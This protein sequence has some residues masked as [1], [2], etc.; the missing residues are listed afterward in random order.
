MENLTFI[1]K[2]ELN[3]KFSKISNEEKIKDLYAKKISFY[4]WGQ[5]GTGKTEKILKLASENGHVVKTMSVTPLSTKGEFFGFMSVD[6]QRYISTPFREA[7]EN[8][9]T[10]LLDEM[11]NIS[12]SLAV[13]LNQSLSQ[14][15]LTFPDKTIEKHENFR[16]LGTG[17]TNGMGGNSSF[18]GRQKMDFS[19]KDRFI[20]IEWSFDE[21]LEY[22]LCKN[23]KWVSL[24]QAIR[25]SIVKNGIGIQVTMRSSIYGDKILESQKNIAILDLLEMTIFKYQISKE[26]RD[27]ILVS[28]ENEILDF[29]NE[30]KK[31]EIEETFSSEKE[32]VET[33]EVKKINKFNFTIGNPEKIEE[34]KSKGF[35]VC[36]IDKSQLQKKNNLF[37]FDGQITLEKLQSIGNE[38]IV[39]VTHT[40]EKKELIKSQLK[41]LGLL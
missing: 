20:P 19:F 3:K 11:D 39:F 15:V 35:S 12:Q 17:N 6:G 2:L 28:V 4:L 40:T 5:A 34:Y 32:T 1:E 33:I 9:Y 27:K 24:V 25:H 18:Q 10:F 37:H 7:Y 31:E 26:T 16:F 8:G 36:T 14:N 41:G 21:K 38:N 22:S 13:S 23:E 30:E 29:L